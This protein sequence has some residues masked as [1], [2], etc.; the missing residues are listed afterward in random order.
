MRSTCSINPSAS[1]T[2]ESMV[3]FCRGAQLLLISSILAAPFRGNRAMAKNRS[4]YD[5]EHDTLYVRVPLAQRAVSTKTTFTE[6]V[7]VRSWP[8]TINWS[9]AP[10]CLVICHFIAAMPSRLPMKAFRLPVRSYLHLVNEQN[11]RS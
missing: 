10:F 5:R 3:A 2:C 8:M 1:G 7:S 6:Q 4:Y 9:S 11:R